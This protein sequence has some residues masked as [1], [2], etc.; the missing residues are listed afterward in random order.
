[1]WSTRLQ[2]ASIVG[3][4]YLDS[5]Q[6]LLTYEYI[7]D[8]SFANTG[9]NRSQLGYAVFLCAENNSANLSSFKSFKSWRV[10]HSVLDAEVCSM[11]E[12]YDEDVAIHYMLATTFNKKICIHMYTDSKSLF[13]TIAKKYITTEKRLTIDLAAF[14][15]AY[16]SHKVSNIA[17]I[18]PQP[19]PADD[20]KDQVE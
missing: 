20:D 11:A 17:L 18:S 14:K 10:V 3:S 15:E 13:D 6:T 5:T 8:G 7:P 4:T 9:D 19:N 12:S 2:K 1:M 16:A